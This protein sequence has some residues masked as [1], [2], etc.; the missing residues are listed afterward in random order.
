VSANTSSIKNQLSQ[1]LRNKEYR[2]AFVVESV[3][4]NVAAQIYALRESRHWTQEELAERARMAQARIS[5]LEDPNYQR[6]TIGTLERLASAFDV[7][8]IVK[9]AAF[10]DLLEWTVAAPCCTSLAVPSFDE[11]MMGLSPGVA[12][13]TEQS[14]IA[15]SRAQ[16]GTSPGIVVNALFDSGQK[17]RDCWASSQAFPIIGNQYK[18]PTAREIQ[19]ESDKERQQREP[20]AA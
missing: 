5:L 20:I 7:G 17:I 16:V 13:G 2:D 10:G 11:E 15:A 4:T 3:G 1:K 14:Q 9:F 19:P 12:C 8:L 6:F 18:L